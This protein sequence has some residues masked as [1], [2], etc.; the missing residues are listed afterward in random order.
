MAL[1]KPK[2]KDIKLDKIAIRKVPDNKGKT[3]KD[4]GSNTGA[5]LNVVKNSTNDTTVK[6]SYDS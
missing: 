5:H 3:P 2:G 1:P 6:N 4:G